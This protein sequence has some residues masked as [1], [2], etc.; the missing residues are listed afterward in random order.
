MQNSRNKA[1]R[2]LIPSFAGFLLFAGLVLSIFSPQ[3]SGASVIDISSLTKDDLE[4]LK[5]EVNINLDSI[6][7][8]VKTMFGNERINIHIDNESFFAVT[9]RGRILE[10][11]KGSL[12]DPTMDVTMS[13]DTIDKIATSDDQVLVLREALRSGEIHYET[14]AVKS[15]V[16]VGMAKMAFNV[17]SWFS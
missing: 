3:T 13:S 16:R 4:V 14:H 2:I 7:R 15:K 10:L 11:E 1:L 17:Y 5:T 6:P 9:K 8:F 12:D